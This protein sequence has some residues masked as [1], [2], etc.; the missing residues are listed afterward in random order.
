MT[1]HFKNGEKTEISQEIGNLLVKLLNSP[2]GC[3][4]W[5]C[6]SNNKT[7]NAELIINFNEIV[8]IK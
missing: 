2:Q 7:D 1:I 4:Q 3:R 6:F 5:Q 8:F